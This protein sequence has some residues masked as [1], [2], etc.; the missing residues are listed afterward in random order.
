MPKKNGSEP[1]Q[2]TQPKKGE[3]VEVPIP[4]REEVFRDL[5]KVAKPRKNAPKGDG[6]GPT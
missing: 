5:G 3:P 6:E 1:T 2:D 4:T